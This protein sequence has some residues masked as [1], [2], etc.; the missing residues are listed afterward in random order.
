MQKENSFRN[1]AA[2]IDVYAQGKRQTQV[3]GGGNNKNDDE[4][5]TVFAIILCDQIQDTRKCGGFLS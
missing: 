4:A 1:G 3:N 5:T 2:K